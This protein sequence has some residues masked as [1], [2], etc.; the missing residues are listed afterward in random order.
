MSI[1]TI[2]NKVFAL[3]A[4]AAKLA[5]ILLAS[6]TKGIGRVINRTIGSKIHSLALVFLPF[7][8][9]GSEMKKLYRPSLLR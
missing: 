4:L 8:I 9:S 7:R 5:H 3:I 2:D 1:G 6:P